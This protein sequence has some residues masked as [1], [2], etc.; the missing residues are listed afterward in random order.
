MYA[1]SQFNKDYGWYEKQ[2]LYDCNYKN[3]PLTPRLEEKIIEHMNKIKEK[4]SS[5]K[6]IEK[7][8]FKVSEKYGVNIKIT[9]GGG[10]EIEYSQ[11]LN[12][13]RK[14]K[15]DGA[16]N[17]LRKELGYKKHWRSMG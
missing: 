13:E 15:R 14:E 7:E 4:P 16:I 11:L 3:N 10:T 9:S 12:K 5:E 8:L 17:K 2:R 6:C 1:S